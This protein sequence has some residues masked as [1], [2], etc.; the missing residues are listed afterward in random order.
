[1]INETDVV[2][3]LFKHK[4][5]GDINPEDFLNLVIQL[6]EVLEYEIEIFN[7][8][9][10]NEKCCFATKF[11]LVEKLH[12]DNNKIHDMYSAT[13]YPHRL[14][15]L[16]FEKTK[17]K[18][19]FKSKGSEIPLN[20]DY[21]KNY[22]NTYLEKSLDIQMENRYDYDSYF[23]ELFPNHDQHIEYMILI[24]YLLAQFCSNETI[25]DKLRHLNIEEEAQRK[26]N[27][28][29]QIYKKRITILMMCCVLR[30]EEK[31]SDAAE[32]NLNNILDEF[33]FSEKIYEHLETILNEKKISNEKYYK[34]IGIIK[35]FRILYKRKIDEEKIKKIFES[36]VDGIKAVEASVQTRPPGY[37][38]INHCRFVYE[39]IN[40]FISVNWFSNNEDNF[41]RSFDRKV[42][43][44][45]T[46]M[47]KKVVKIPCSGSEL[48]DKYSFRDLM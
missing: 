36:A 15:N 24:L 47:H 28:R 5:E 14:F 1:M 12:I 6:V 39:M 41:I 42:F 32:K 26:M 29:L 11:Y 19:D 3:H 27:E 4:C 10:V 34:E 2:L 44:I 30:I 38:T 17:S 25:Q 46:N 20:A 22:F 35:L 31:L 16:S 21:I 9:I 7:E 8:T 33:E 18:K 37:N 48:I 13:K 40:I 45:A 43:D 23:S